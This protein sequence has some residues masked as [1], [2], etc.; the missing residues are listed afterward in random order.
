MANHLRIDFWL[1]GQDWTQP[2]DFAIEE[3]VFFLL[4]T[5]LSHVQLQHLLGESR[6][7]T[8]IWPSARVIGAVFTVRSMVVV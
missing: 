4:D 1:T 8:S 3:A 7:H 5:P 2:R 6:L